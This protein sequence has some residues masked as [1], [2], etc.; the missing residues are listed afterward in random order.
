MIV[1]VLLLAALIVGGR[2]YQHG[3][4]TSSVHASALSEARGCSMR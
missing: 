2:F 3:L 1:G 4:V